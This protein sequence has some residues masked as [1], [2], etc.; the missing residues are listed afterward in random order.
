MQLPKLVVFDMAGTTV[1]DRGEVPA[2]FKAALAEQGLDVSAE[3]LNAVRGASKRQAVF[4][5]LPDGPDRAARADT[6]YSSFKLHLARRYAEGVR[7]V[8]GALE[9]FAWLRERSV[10]VALNTGFDGEITDLLL[11]AL[12]WKSGVVDGVVCGDEVRRG[13]PAPQLIFRCMEATDTTGVHDVAVVGDTTLDLQAAH[14]AGVRWNIGVLSG[15]HSREQLQQQPHTH[16]LPSV[17]ELPSVWQ[18]V[19]PLAL[20]HGDLPDESFEWGTLWW[21]CNARIS[22]GAIQTVGICQIMPGG[23]NPVHYHPNCDEVLYMLSGEGQHSYD[24]QLIPLRAGST[25]RIPAGVKHNLANT[26]TQTITC[27][28]SFSSGNRETVFLE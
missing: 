26:G 21:L 12:G 13:R 18:A 17:R 23:R 6:A 20:A 10:R 7:A 1:Q 22:P 11:G 15:A 9:T 19:P 4:D 2:A 28:I 5:L 14:H 27:L 25:L 8:P 24:G 3:E 16:L